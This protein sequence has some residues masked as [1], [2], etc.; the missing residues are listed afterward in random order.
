MLN[1]NYIIFKSFIQL[2]KCLTLCKTAPLRNTSEVCVPTKILNLFWAIL[3]EFIDICFN[4]PYRISKLPYCITVSL[5]QRITTANVEKMIL[6]ESLDY[7]FFLFIFAKIHRVNS[8]PPYLFSLP[9]YFR[10]YFKS[11]SAMC[12]I[13]SIKCM[14]VCV[15][16]CVRE[17]EREKERE[18]SVVF[19]SLQPSGL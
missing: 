4:E 1:Q 14:C 13:I 10:K 15:C 16:V 3:Q 9:K 6:S 5:K 18:K 7:C 11:N 2:C 8:S 12:S 17:R 19:K